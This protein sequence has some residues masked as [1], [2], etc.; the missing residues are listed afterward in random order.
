[1]AVIDRLEPLV[2][3]IVDDLGVELFDLEH[4]GGTVRV[5]VEREGG[6]DMEA[7]AEITRRVS[8]MLDEHDPLPG[9]YTL[10]VSSPGLERTL[11]TPQH[12]RWAIGKLVRIKTRPGTEGDRR[13]EG[14]IVAADEEAVTVELSGATDPA[15]P[16]A[17]R[18]IA[19]GDIE[20]TR[21]VF[22]WGPQPKPGGRSGNKKPSDKTAGKAAKGRTAKDKAAK[23]ARAA[24]AAEKAAATPEGG[25]QADRD[26]TKE[27]KVDR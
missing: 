27:A 9:K 19:Y 11:R 25:E 4:E 2:R 24:R 21:T 20:R 22:E 1:M 23:Q 12:H 14:T 7:I 10:E 16:E 8:R 6:V 26:P 13:V 17:R 5:T 18:V 15:D 3:P